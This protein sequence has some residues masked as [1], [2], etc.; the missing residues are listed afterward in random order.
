M[1]G[2]AT[3][4][5][6]LDAGLLIA[7]SEAILAAQEI[8]AGH[9]AEDE[10]REEER[11]RR[12]A[13]RH[14]LREAAAAGRQEKA[15]QAAILE[16]RLRRLAEAWRELGRDGLDVSAPPPA[17]EE[18]TAIARHLALLEQRIAGLEAAFRDLA[19]EMPAADLSALLEA[20]VSAEEQ[21]AYHAARAR[22][23]L[24]A[25]LAEARRALAD[26]LLER[27]DLEPA[28]P[29]PAAIDALAAQL[30]AAADAG[31]AE[32][33]ATEIR[34][35]VQRH[36]ETRAAERQAA[37]EAAQKARLDEAAALVLEQS[38]RDLG[39]AVED[40]AE[41]LFVEGGLIHFQRPGWGDYHIRL[42]LD[43]ARGAINFNVVRAAGTGDD[44]VREDLMA[45]ER[46][47]AE[48]P[49][50]LETLKARGVNLQVT[51]LL[52][53]GEVPVLQVDPASLPQR[54]EE[55]RRHEAAP[56]SRSLG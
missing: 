54:H 34:L 25:E 10:R 35:Q 6:G 24:A 18:P 55:E 23:A 15:R 5:F 12:R 49:R 30:I 33:L 19:A 32:A 20:G 27:L 3:A 13:E 22:R 46:W 14:Q 8:A 37:A 51:R 29:L 31:R 39:Y 16:A 2:P 26:R 56:I 28:E 40:I 45:E 44:R 17:P 4:A 11:D 38:L 7:A 9:A 36:N 21:L 1:S 53:A 47:C 52:Q 50:L 42:R 41:T 43:P 48:F